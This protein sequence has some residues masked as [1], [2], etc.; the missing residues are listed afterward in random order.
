MLI[1]LKKKTWLP[2][3]NICDCYFAFY[4]HFQKECDPQTRNTL[5]IIDINKNQTNLA[6]KNK[7]LV[8]VTLK[9]FAKT[10]TSTK[11]GIFK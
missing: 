5:L 2:N 7:I 9:A 11:Q 1:D 10:N 8:T 4:R 6:V 3:I